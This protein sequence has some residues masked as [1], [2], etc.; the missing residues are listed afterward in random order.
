VGCLSQ[1][2]VILEPSVSETGE[3]M[4]GSSIYNNNITYKNEQSSSF[5]FTK[6]FKTLDGI[7][8]LSPEQILELKTFVQENI[9]ESNFLISKISVHN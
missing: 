5:E 1:K 7:S 6:L 4:P 8:N 2:V 3:G 9:N